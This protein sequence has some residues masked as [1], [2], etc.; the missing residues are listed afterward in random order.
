MSTTGVNADSIA[1]DV[2]PDRLFAYCLG[3]GDNALIL[4]QRLAEWS[5]KAP[6]LE[7]DIALSNHA[8]DLF[9][10]ASMLYTYAAEVEGQGRDEDALAFLRDV[11]DFRNVLLVEQPNGDFADTIV[12]HVLYT[13]F[14]VEQ[15]DRL[16]VSA[17]AR[18]AAIGAKAVRELSY[19]LRHTGEWLVRL[20][21]GTDESHQR[22]QKGLDN[23]WAYT[24][25]LFEC[26]PEIAGIVDAGIGPD[27]A[28]LKPA[29]D[30][31]LDGILDRA[32]LTRP[33]DGWMQTG[34]LEGRH[35]EHLGFM[36]ADMQ[37]MQRAYPGAKW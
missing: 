14:A 26:G 36:L 8:L 4:G 19:H 9:G 25:E 17:D 29:W 13:A 21:D 7:V 35:S 20:G 6:S 2:S 34:G 23:L 15:Y 30:K 3:L 24:G 10:Q 1:G 37:F 27:P 32:T 18:L 5:S 22:A 11:S 12:R 28:E 16:A 33:A 31:T